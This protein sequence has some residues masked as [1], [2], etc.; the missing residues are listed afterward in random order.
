MVG[1]W[2]HPVLDDDVTRLAGHEQTEDAGMP[3]R[4]PVGFRTGRRETVEMPVMT[5]RRAATVGQEVL[6]LP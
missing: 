5:A 1:G 3:L 4:D 6:V 2:P